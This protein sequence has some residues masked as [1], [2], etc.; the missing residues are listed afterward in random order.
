MPQS[1]RS[2]AKFTARAI[3][4]CHSCSG[5]HLRVPIWFHDYRWQSQAEGCA[6]SDDG[7]ELH[8]AIVP[9]HDL[10]SLRQ[11]DSASTFVALGG[12]VEFKN[13]LLRFGGNAATLVLHLGENHLVIAPRLQSERATL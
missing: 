11:A 13:L 4:A 6:G 3:P 9:L 12:E 1:P 10:I 7:I 8:R 2:A 5:R